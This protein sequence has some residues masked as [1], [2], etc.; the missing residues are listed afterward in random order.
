MLDDGLVGPQDHIIPEVPRLLLPDDRLDEQTVEE[1]QDG[2]LHVLVPRVRHIAGLERA[3]GVPAALRERRSGL[4]R[5][6]VVVGVGAAVVVEKV[7]R[8]CQ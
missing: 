4:G 3:H 7:D 5:K 1:P 6:Q 8:A 2:L